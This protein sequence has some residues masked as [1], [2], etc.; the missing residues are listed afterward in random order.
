V[1]W[2]TALAELPKIIPVALGGV[3][4]IA[5]GVAAQTLT[6][7]LSE[8]REQRKLFREKA[9]ALIAALY[10]HR[11][12]LKSENNRLVFGSDL[13]ELPS[14]LDR[15]YAIQELYFPDLAKSLVGIN[16]SMKNILPYFAKHAKARLTNKE[17]WI[18]SFDGNEF[19][20]LY[21]AYLAAWQ[22]AINDVVRIAR[23]HVEN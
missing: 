17:V 9:E 22:C 1:D 2:N 5:G 15:A 16:S 3:L 19:T 11:E 13:Q 21:E 20:P 18:K 23:K 14:P 7:V 8:R 6:H 4:A 10:E 12:W